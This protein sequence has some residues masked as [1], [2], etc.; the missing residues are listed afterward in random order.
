MIHISS[1][2][3]GKVTKIMRKKSAISILLI[4]AIGIF[5]VVSG[6]NSRWNNIARASGQIN[7]NFSFAM[8]KLLSKVVGFSGNDA[9]AFKKEVAY[10]NSLIIS[11]HIV[12]LPENQ[13]AA[14]VYEMTK[15][16]NGIIN[17]KTINIEKCKEEFYYGVARVTNQ[18]H[19]TDDNDGVPRQVQDLDGSGYGNANVNTYVSGSG[20]NANVST[21][22]T[23]SKTQT[24]S[25]K[26]GDSVVT[27]TNTITSTDTDGAGFSNDQY[28][29]PVAS[30]KKAAQKQQDNDPNFI[31]PQT[32]NILIDRINNPVKPSKDEMRIFDKKFLGEPVEIDGELRIH[33]MSNKSDNPLWAR[34]RAGVRLRLAA[35][36]HLYDGWRIYTMTEVLRSIRYYNNDESILARLYLAGYIGEVYTTVGKFGYLMANGNIY[37]SMFKGL[38][39]QYG[40]DKDKYEYAL[41]FGETNGSDD[42]AVATIKYRDFDY[43]LELGAYNFRLYETGQSTGLF[44]VGGLYRLSNYTLGAL[45]LRSTLD[46]FNGD[47]DGFVLSL[48]YGDLKSWRK[49]TYSLFAKYYDQARYTYITHGMEGMGQWM[50]GFKGWGAGMNYTIMENMVAGLYYYDLEEKYSGVKGKTWWTQLSYYF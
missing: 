6:V 5:P 13:R 30:Y 50:H 12:S 23:T 31:S 27:S 41:A 37:D 45:Y 19:K 32:Y 21:A 38:R 29:V 44:T 49:G 8:V 28:N 48:Y 39:L 24:Q 3:F 17:R 16:S 2:F 4:L 10:A 42:T 22:T 26:T 14:F 7:A 9:E 34:S 47:R 43:E 18:V 11:Q 46:D 20:G 1:K 36:T 35:N 25:I 33:S 15:L 40:G